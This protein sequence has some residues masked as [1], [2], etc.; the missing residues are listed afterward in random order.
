MEIRTKYVAASALFIGLIITATFIV[1]PMAN[2]IDDSDDLLE[3]G[4][5]DWNVGDKFYYHIGDSYYNENK[6]VNYRNY[7]SLL[8]SEVIHIGDLEVDNDGLDDIGF[9]SSTLIGDE[10]IGAES[11]VIFDLYQVFSLISIISGEE[12]YDPISGE[13]F[14]FFAEPSSVHIAL[15]SFYLTLIELSEKFPDPENLV[16]LLIQGGG[17]SFFEAGDEDSGLDLSALAAQLATFIFSDYDFLDVAEGELHPDFSWESD[18]KI[19]NEAGV[20]LSTWAKYGNMIRMYQSGSQSAD[21][22]LSWDYLQSRNYT[23]GVEEMLNY[24][25]WSDTRKY[26]FTFRYN[27]TSDRNTT[28]ELGQD[29]YH[30]QET[31]NPSTDFPTIGFNGIRV[32]F[33][34]TGLYNQIGSHYFDGTYI[35]NTPLEL[36]NTW[37]KIFDYSEVSDF[38][39]DQPIRYIFNTY[40]DI[41]PMKYNITMIQLKEGDQ[42]YTIG[43]FDNLGYYL[44]SNY[45]GKVK[46]YTENSE[47]FWA[48]GD[49]VALN[50]HKLRIIQSENNAEGDDLFDDFTFENA[51]IIELATEKV[52]SADNLI[53]ETLGLGISFYHFLLLPDTFDMNVITFFIETLNIILDN[54]FRIMDMSGILEEVG[55]DYLKELEA[56]EFPEEYWELPY[57]PF[58][59][60]ETDDL[61]SIELDERV[62]ILVMS[63]L[64][65]LLSSNLRF[66]TGKQVLGLSMSWDKK[67]RMFNELLVH[68]TMPEI[69]MQREVGIKLVC[70]TRPNDGVPTKIPKEYSLFS[71]DLLMN[72]IEANYGAIQ[73]YLL[74][75]LWPVMLGAAVGVI[76]ASVG[77][78]Q[79]IVSLTRRKRLYD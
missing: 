65:T 4:W 30:W 63:L 58:S 55:I 52:L 8:K 7:G 28:I 66:L 9:I 14:R 59:I 33:N 3:Y 22:T 56:L 54:L 27:Q 42:F 35:A 67:A 29:F 6:S 53:M 51:R 77:I 21:S 10:F 43:G 2:V 31:Q 49:F 23:N 18:D 36:I 34:E 25:Y 75:K 74:G 19:Q 5:S 57:S 62:W 32:M 13:F 79:I 48:N 16:S 12:N 69:D 38:D 11:P 46:Y 50:F 64:K 44:E 47:N 71:D 37:V 40:Q 73:S 26:D 61:I 70:T 24:L 1:P 17:A 68:I 15:S 41:S 78:S 20:F 60:T 45:E 72:L 39:F 76:A